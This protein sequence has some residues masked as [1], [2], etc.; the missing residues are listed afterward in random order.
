VPQAQQRLGNE[1]VVVRVGDDSEV[2]LFGQILIGEALDAC[3][4]RCHAY[5]GVRK[6]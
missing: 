6:D 2:D 3:C 4:L 5:P 1:V